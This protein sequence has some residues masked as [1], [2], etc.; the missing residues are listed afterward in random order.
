MGMKH[1]NFGA[2]LQGIR[3][4]ELQRKY[5][6][7][8]LHLRCLASVQMDNSTLTADLQGLYLSIR[9]I[10]VRLGRLPWLCLGWRELLHRGMNLRDRK[11]D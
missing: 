11:I 6:L 1:F 8:V 10:P 4:M 3:E 5:A 2:P 9:H 7:G